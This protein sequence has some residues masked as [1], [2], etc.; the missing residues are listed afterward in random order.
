MLGSARRR[1]A[2]NWRLAQ[3]AALGVAAGLILFPLIGFPLARKLPFGS[4]SDRP[5]TAARG[6]GDWR[7]GARVDTEPSLSPS[8][9]A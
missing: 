3:V 7:G 2:Q 1:E 6:E 5:A 4:L 9:A 8:R